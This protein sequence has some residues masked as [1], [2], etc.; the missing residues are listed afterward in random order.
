MTSF[1]ITIVL[2]A[3][4]VVCA[5]AVY[6]GIVTTTSVGNST[7]VGVILERIF[8]FVGVYVT[9]SA[10]IATAFAAGRRIHGRF[11]DDVRVGEVY[12]LAHVM[13]NLDSEPAT[14]WNNMGYWSAAVDSSTVRDFKLAAE[15]LA[16]KLSVAARLSS[17]DTVVDVG[18]GCGDQSVLYSRL[19]GQYIGITSLQSQSDIAYAALAKRDML[20]NAH[21]LTLDASDP[22]NTWPSD[23]LK[24]AVAD[25][26]VN[27]ILALDCLYHFQPSREKFFKFVNVTLESAFEKR[28][29]CG[30]ITEVCFA[31]ED[32]LKGRELNFSQR[33]RMRLICAFART[34][35]NNFISVQEYASLL[36]N[37]GFTNEHGWSVQF[38]DISDHVFPGLSN[39]LELR[40]SGQDGIGKYLRFEKFTA[41]G[42][43][44]RWW[45]DDGVV[46]AYIVTIRK[47]VAR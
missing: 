1:R 44:V 42:K 16:T 12:D 41:F 4:K 37:S 23:L 39:F 5:A 6:V 38:E 14:T 34:P 22:L 32:L 9:I 21:I 29:Q 20:G 3:A 24:T 45:H 36:E 26:A 35:F 8:L 7:Y 28:L 19:V 43:V 30:D 31:A 18:I 47:M 40:G 33:L 15:S 27:K 25:G 46:K 17:A 13:L 10:I 11:T 2:V